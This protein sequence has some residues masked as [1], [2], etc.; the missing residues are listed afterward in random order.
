[1]KLANLSFAIKSVYLLGLIQILH[2]M[3]KN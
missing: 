2:K 1:M 3:P